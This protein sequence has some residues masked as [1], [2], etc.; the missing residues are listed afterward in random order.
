M[1]Q[2]ESSDFLV[3]RWLI[4]PS[5]RAKSKA[6]QSFLSPNTRLSLGFCYL[7]RTTNIS[8]C[9]NSCMFSFTGYFLFSVSIFTKKK[10]SIPLNL[11]DFGTDLNGCKERPPSGNILCLFRRQTH[12]VRAVVIK[13]PKRGS[14]QCS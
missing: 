6:V 14:T 9:F 13:G 7:S 4:S 3:K 5:C 10:I 8:F 1:N 2:S 11:L 12:I